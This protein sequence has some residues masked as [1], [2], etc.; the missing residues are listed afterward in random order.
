MQREDQP[1]MATKL[2]QI[3]APELCISLNGSCK[4]SQ[5]C[6]PTAEE[7]GARNLHAG[8]CGN[9]GRATASSDPV[10]GQPKHHG[11]PTRARS[12]KRRIQTRSAYSDFA[13]ISPTRRGTRC[14]WPES[15]R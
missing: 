2:E 6:E 1:T 11:E 7:P 3:A 8:F 15:L 10:R 5:C 14:S 13:Q 9:G 4:H 12:R